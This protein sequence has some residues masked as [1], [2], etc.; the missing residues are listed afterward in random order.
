MG[1]LQS[2]E[3]RLSSL[4]EGAFAKVF[5]G[6]VEPVE[7]AG[8]L[9]RECDD[10]R[11]ISSRR[12]L[13]PNAFVVDLSDK[14]AERLT[15]YAEPL[16]EELATL[17][18]EH[19]DEA[20]YSF[21]GPVT[22]RLA[23]DPELATGVFRVHAEV[24]SDGA[25]SA[26]VSPVPL[27]PAV[28]EAEAERDRD[29][30]ADG[31]AAAPLNVAPPDVAPPIGIR[32]SPAAPTQ[33]VLVLTGGGSAPVGT[34]EADGRERQFVLAGAVTRIGRAHDVDL[35]LDDTAVSRH[36]AELRRLPATSAA[37]PG[38]HLLV[39]LGSTN[40]TLVDGRRVE[41]AQLHDGDRIEIGSSTL[42][43]RTSGEHP[44]R[45]GRQGGEGSGPAVEA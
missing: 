1:V 42:V 30:A 35:R 17:V 11:V 2:F 28:H 6:G 14:D 16:T 44:R 37:E 23:H 32:A 25:V 8:A 33:A 18:R 3:R 21:A 22:V 41:T 10:R 9:T 15:P 24:S 13:V 39:D 40:G 31:P 45:D 36:H 26:P 38:G 7:I 12:T 4:V 43:Y 27:P 5:K 34:P 19:A 29:Q 20:R